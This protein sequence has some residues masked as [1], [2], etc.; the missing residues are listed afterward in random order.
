MVRFPVH[1][2]CF[3]SLS[4]AR[5]LAPLFVLLSLAGLFFFWGFACPLSYFLYSSNHLVLTWSL[6]FRSLSLSPPLSLCHVISPV[7][8]GFSNRISGVDIPGRIMGRG[9]VGGRPIWLGI[10]VSQPLNPP[11]SAHTYIL[12]KVGILWHIYTHS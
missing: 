12:P 10:K 3:L 5:S 7:C 9:E 2:L 8:K 11:G 4:L 6:S 1:F